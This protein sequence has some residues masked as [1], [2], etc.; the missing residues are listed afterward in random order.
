[1][2]IFAGVAI[3]SCQ[4]MVRHADHL[5]PANAVHGFNGNDRGFV[6]HDAAV[7][8]IDDGVHRAQVNGHVVIG[9]CEDAGQS[10]GY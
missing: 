2:K 9:G 3:A 10:H 6:E 1:M 5:D 8:D 7:A 4:M